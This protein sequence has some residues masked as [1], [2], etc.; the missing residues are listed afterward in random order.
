MSDTK[1]KAAPAS[2]DEKVQE[3]LAI[4]GDL[5]QRVGYHQAAPTSLAGQVRDH[6]FVGYQPYPTAELQQYARDF[7]GVNPWMGPWMAQPVAVRPE[8]FSG[9]SREL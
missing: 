6:K 5:Y 7:S 9:P 3:L 8:P 4:L 2:R 1:G